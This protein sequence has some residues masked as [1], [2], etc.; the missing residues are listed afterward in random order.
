MRVLMLIDSY[1]PGIGGAQQHVRNLSIALAARGHT[2]SVAT[3]ANRDQPAYEEDAGVRVYRMRGTLQHTGR[4]FRDPG[5]AYA[6][7]LPDPA[8][9]AALRHIIMRERPHVVHA[10]N[11]LLHSFLPLKRWS[12]ARLVVSLHDYGLRCATWIMMHH[13]HP[14]SGPGF[15]KCLAC[16]SG[17]YGAA[18][19]IPITLGNWAMGVP[20]RALVDMFVPVSRAVVDGN[21]LIG[22]RLPY[23]VIPNFIPDDV[24]EGFDDSL[25][26]REQLPQDGYLLFVG[27]LSRQ[28]GIVTLLEAYAGIAC[29]PPLVLI[30]YTLHD[31]PQAFP[32]N[33]I[34]RKNWPHAAVMTAWRHSLIG[35]V[36]SIWPDP[37]P[38]V[39]MEAMAVGKPVI[40]SR[41]GGLPDIVVDGETGL[42]VPPD[43]AVALRGPTKRHR[44]PRE[45]GRRADR[46]AL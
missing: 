45:H 27:S 34:V 24:G 30:G 5:R 10:H 8:L 11:W 21:D 32:P 42:L 23:R 25:T 13:G 36:P 19:G 9:I 31:T 7:P 15:T 37:C 1:P 26:Y 16:A 39:A 46:T 17:N 6:P 40:A 14:C 41:I 43:D 33:V 3:L 2:I 35:V 28:K 4:I 44:F 12:G 22:D 20:E 38:T 29:A 18:K